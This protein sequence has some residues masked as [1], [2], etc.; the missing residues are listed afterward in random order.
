MKTLKNIFSLGLITGLLFV[1]MQ[2]FAGGMANGTGTFSHTSN[3]KN[4]LKLST[5]WMPFDESKINTSVKVEVVFMTD[6]SG[7][8]S[9][10]LAKSQ[11]QELKVELE[12]QFSKFFLPQLRKNV[13]HTVTLN[14]VYTKAENENG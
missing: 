1:S 10:V 9:F 2:S 4:H 14:I 7:Y 12:K 11:D 6:Q 5:I 8:V 3:V 13:P